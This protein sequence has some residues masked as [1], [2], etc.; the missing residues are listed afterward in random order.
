MNHRSTVV[1]TGALAGGLLA[2]ALAALLIGRFAIESIS[3]TDGGDAELV[4]RGGALYLAG[5]IAALVGGAGIGVVAY[6]ASTEDDDAAR[7]E[8]AHILPFGLATALIAGY[9]VLR[10][11]IGFAGDAA[12]GTVSITIAALAFTALVAGLVTGGATAWVVSVLAAKEIVGFEGEAAPASTAAMMRAAAQAIMGPMLAIVVIAAL[13]ISL[14]QLLLAAEGAAAIAIF[15]G[16]A[17]L[18]LFGA[19]ATA[20]LGGNDTPAD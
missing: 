2:V 18:V 3:L 17:A 13:A 6:G 9:S 4:V 12:A 20:Y 11:G 14:A 16:V 8:L 19:A 5:A 15:G 10:A 7:F 1:L